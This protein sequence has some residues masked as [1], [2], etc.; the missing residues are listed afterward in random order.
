MNIQTLSAPERILL[1]EELWESV[2]GN[3]EDV[4]L[5]ADQARLLESRLNALESDGELGDSW[6]NVK[7]RLL[8]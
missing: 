8:T 7:S 3:P 2:R 1:A 5:T 4:E 6:V